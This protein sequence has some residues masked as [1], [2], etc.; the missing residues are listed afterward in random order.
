MFEGFGIG[1]IPRLKKGSR[2]HIRGVWWWQKSY[3]NPYC[4][5]AVYVDDEL[6]AVSRDYEYGGADMIRQQ[7][8]AALESKIAMPYGVKKGSVSRYDL[9]QKG[10]HFSENIKEVRTQRQLKEF[11]RRMN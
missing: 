5:W 4:A 9:R 11:V 7:A 3:G 2:V 1:A 10:V 8:M 6:L